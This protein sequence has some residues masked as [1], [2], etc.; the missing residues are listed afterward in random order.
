MLGN[1]RAERNS[2]AYDYFH[3]TTGVERDTSFAEI[4]ILKTGFDLV[5]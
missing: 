5:K 1:A 3:I 2:F 4:A